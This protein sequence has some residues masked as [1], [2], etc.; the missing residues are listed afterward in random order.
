VNSDDI[1][2][3]I[4]KTSKLK[5]SKYK[6]STTTKEIRNY[7]KKNKFSTVK[8][9]DPFLWKNIKIIDNTILFKL[10]ENY[11]SYVAA[12]TAS[13]IRK[14][15]LDNN[16]SFSFE[17]VMSHPGKLDLIKEAKEKEYKIYLYFV[18]TEDPQINKYR[19]TVRVKQDG[20][21]VK[22]RSIR[23]RYFRCMRNLKDA[24][25]LTDRAYIFDNTDASQLIA[26]ITDGWNVE[27]IDD[28]NIPYWFVKYLYN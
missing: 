9:E 16:E 1:E 28:E 20:H 19:V 11:L 21:P 13:F 6:I 26:E 8:L 25:K 22:P 14:K 23:N 2:S 18:S 12:D 24:V 10:P 5:L 17:T 7:F 4:R 27:I 15:L 3:I